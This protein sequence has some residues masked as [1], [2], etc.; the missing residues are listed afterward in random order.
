MT[1]TLP[2]LGASGTGSASAAPADFAPAPVTSKHEFPLLLWLLA[3]LALAAG[4]V[5]LFW[6]NRT[7]E[8]YAGGAQFD[9]FVAPEPPP[10]PAPAPP[11]AAPPPPVA[12][13]KP[14]P[15]S[16]G[17]VSSRLRPWVQIAFNPTRCVLDDQSVT[18]EFELELFNSGSARARGVRVDA[19]IFNAGSDQDSQIG[20]FFANPAGRGESIEIPPLKRLNL[21]T[22][23]AVPRT[24]MQPYELA[25]K[26][27]FVP[28]IAFNALYGWS[29]GEGQTS[30]TYL[31]GR[32]T[33]AEKL[34]PF[35]IDLGPRI[36]RSIAAR[37]LPTGLQ[38]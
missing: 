1:A 9:H 14:A 38:N 17:L 19:A 12:A 8:A 13:P 4:G 2:T 5:F 3:A 18:V 29:G 24:Q 7:R 30:T 6:R 36:F 22:K 10:R 37:L 21:K 32:D 33:K 35:R 11:R 28:V 27:V 20:N 23:V 26:Q 25:G 16:P 31:L 34:A 15:A